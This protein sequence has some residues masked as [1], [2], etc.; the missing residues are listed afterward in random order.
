[1][2][3]QC[4]RMPHVMFADSGHESFNDEHARSQTLGCRD[5]HVANTPP[6]VFHGQVLEMLLGGGDRNDAR[7]QFAGLHALPEF[8]ASQFAQQ[9]FGFSHGWSRLSVGFQRDSARPGK[10]GMDKLPLHFWLEVGRRSVVA[11]SWTLLYRGVALGGA[12][13][14]ATVRARF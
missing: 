11:Q 9:D 1:W 12:S 14:S 5:G 8:A 10:R 3:R 13:D 4:S 7:L 2:Q 6:V